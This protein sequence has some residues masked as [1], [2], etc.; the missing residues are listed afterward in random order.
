MKVSVFPMFGVANFREYIIWTKKEEKPT[1]LPSFVGF[2]SFLTN[3]Y[4]LFLYKMSSESPL[5]QI[6]PEVAS[7][8]S[9][10]S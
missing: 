6:L 2:S 8:S 3:T 5:D 9:L 10:S 7:K 1:K 4:F